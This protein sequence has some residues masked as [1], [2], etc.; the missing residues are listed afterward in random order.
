[1]AYHGSTDGGGAHISPMC[2]GSCCLLDGD[3]YG[4]SIGEGGWAC[5]MPH[6]SDNVFA[7]QHCSLVANCFDKQ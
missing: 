2:A 5:V 3:L 7:S 1:M 4:D 6:I